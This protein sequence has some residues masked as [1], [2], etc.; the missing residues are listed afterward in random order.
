MLRRVISACVC[1]CASAALANGRFPAPITVVFRAGAP[2]D[3]LVATTF[4]ALM[5]RDGGQTWRWFCEGAVGYGG[6]YDPTWLWLSDGAIFATTFDGLSVSRDGGCNWDAVPGTERLFIEDVQGHPGEPAT[7]LITT[8]KSGIPSTLLRSKDGGR[9]FPETL[10]SRTDTFFSGVRVAPSDPRHLYAGSF[11]VNPWRGAIHH[12]ADSGQTWEDFAQDVLANEPIQL[13]AVDPT[14]PAVMFVRRRGVQK[15]VILRSEDFGRTLSP[16]LEAEDELKV[17]LP[18]GSSTTFW[19]AGTSV[20]I[21][22]SDDGGKTFGAVP[23]SPQ[24]ACLATDG[25]SLYSCGSAIRDGFVVGVRQGDGSF[26]SYIGSFRDIDGPL[27]CAPDSLM[28]EF[29][30]DQWPQY[31]ALFGIPLAD[32]GVQDGGGADGGTAPPPAPKGC[33]CQAGASGALGALLAAVALW[34]GRRRRT[35][36]CRGQSRP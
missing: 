35:D 1:L 2:Q 12:S 32:G 21:F 34:A 8:N 5:T 4:G 26:R 18:F 17:V 24:A 22:R 31:A 9:T 13:L 11:W 16:V 27:G 19:A 36:S 25:A 6:S 3:A 14:N 30:A 23:G 15:D 28:Q 20:G 33:G 7:V 29:C 10:L